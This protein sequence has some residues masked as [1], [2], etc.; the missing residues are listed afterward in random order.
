MGQPLDRIDDAEATATGGFVFGDEPRQV[1]SRAE[2]LER[3]STLVRSWEGCANVA[4]IDVARYDQ[5]D[6]DGCNWS[7]SVVLDPAGVA[8]EV[9]ALAYAA[10]IANARASWNLE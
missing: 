2:L 9:Y 10:V 7:P 4:V 6:S 3:L 5:P 1:L 8:P